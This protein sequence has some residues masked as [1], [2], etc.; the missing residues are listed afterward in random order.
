ME[1]YHYQGEE[2]SVFALAHHWK[3]YV[4]GIVK[5][6]LQGDVLEVGAGLG[7]NLTYLLS[8]KATAWC[9]LEP[10]ADNCL[11]LQQRIDKEAILDKCRVQQGSLKDI[12][13]HE[14]FD[15]IL[16]YDVL[17]HI[18]DDGLELQQA[19]KHLKPGGRLIILSPAHQAM[20]SGFD[21]AIGHYRRYNKSSLCA[22][23]PASLSRQCLVYLDSMGFLAYKAFSRFSKEERIS[24]K[25]VLFWDRCLIPLSR[26]FDPLFG[27]RL[28]KTILGVW[29][30]VT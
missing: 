23:V 20:F 10:D 29:Q 4:A 19:S 5:P 26:I 8:E 21:K 27:H 18:E 17:E 13:G 22:A 7:S 30:K 1:S 14:M 15:S 11:V 9:C 6:L 25:R 3:T 12:P 2:L 28:G 16:Y 24:R